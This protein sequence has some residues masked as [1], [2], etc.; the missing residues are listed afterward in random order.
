VDKV[1]PTPNQQ[2][3]SLYVSEYEKLKQEQV[4][5]MGF[6]DNLIY[7]NLI[8]ITGIISIVSDNTSR[9]PALL[10]LPLICLTLGWTYL[11][12]DEKI[13]AIGR[14][15]RN[16]LT[17]RVRQMVNSDDQMLFGWEI[18]HRD[19]KRRVSRKVIQLIV[20]E[21]V[22]IIPGIIAI[23][24][25][26]LSATNGSMWLKWI[27]AVEVLFLLVLGMQIIG[28]ADLKKGK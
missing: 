1:D 3:L 15:I 22:F 7:A 14:Y 23:I 25:F 12:N 5:R 26:W 18:A 19:D 11:V 8:A 28:Y 9:F 24:V 10:V 21:T 4:H 6:R 27:A 16:V 13:S 17:D 2:V 20:D